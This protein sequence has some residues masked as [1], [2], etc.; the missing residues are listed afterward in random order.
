MNILYVCPKCK[1]LARVTYKGGYIVTVC[2]E[3]CGLIHN[4]N[5]TWLSDWMLSYPYGC[6]PAVGESEYDDFVRL[7][8]V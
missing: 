5:W 3:H 1:H 2:C 7:S 4:D 6:F 8:A